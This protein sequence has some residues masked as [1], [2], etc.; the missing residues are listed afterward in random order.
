L[1][2]QE[3]EKADNCLNADLMY[4][5]SRDYYQ[6]QI[7]AC[8]HTISKEKRALLYT[9]KFELYSLYEMQKAIDIKCLRFL[10]KMTLPQKDPLK[11]R[12]KELR[13]ICIEFMI[14][15]PIIGEELYDPNAFDY[16]NEANT[17]ADRITT[18]FQKDIGSYHKYKSNSRRMMEREVR[19]SEAFL[20]KE[21][22]QNARTRA[23]VILAKKGFGKCTI[24][25]LN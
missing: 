13:R 20:Q 16:S 21:Q 15:N 2:E 17:F 6:N 25:E 9:R 1:I 4:Q 7:N 12:T 10:L 22:E 19:Q 5:H 3:I 8:H 18:Q 24:E 14:N 23:A 11:E